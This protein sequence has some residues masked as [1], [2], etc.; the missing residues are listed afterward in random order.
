MDPTMCDEHR[1]QTI[2]CGN[3]SHLSGASAGIRHSVG[4][5]RLAVCRGLEV[6]FLCRQY[7]A[8]FRRM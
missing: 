4:G 1:V 3:L 5:S 2:N 7:T 8:L 6:D